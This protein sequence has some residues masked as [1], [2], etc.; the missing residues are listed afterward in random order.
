MIF[1]SWISASTLTCELS[2]PRR[3]ERKATWAP[4]SSPVMYS[5]GTWARCK[6]SSAWSRSVDLPMPGSP[7]ISTTPPSTMPPPST[8]SSSP[9]PVGCLST[10]LA[11][12]SDS[13]ATADDFVSGAKR[14]RPA[15]GDSATVSISVFQA[16]Q[17]G[18]LPSHLALV[19]PHS[20]QVKVV[21]SLATRQCSDASDDPAVRAAIQLDVLAA[22][23]RRLLAAQVR[24]HIRKFFRPAEALG[25]DRVGEFLPRGFG[26]DVV[27]LR[28]AFDQVLLA[29]RIDAFRQQVVDGDVVDDAFGGDRLAQRGE[30]RARRRRQPLVRARRLHHCGRDV[31]DAAELALA[32]PGQQRA[33]EERSRDH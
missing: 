21:F 8:R 24:A 26:R 15:T 20:V 5:V 12:I 29:R 23:E 16:S 28:L 7:P 31:D 11:S 33:N 14:C 10:S 17:C 4:L 32:H 3:R 19:P 6:A 2:R 18:H 1:S 9:M 25:G 22:D 27:H 13:T 30:R